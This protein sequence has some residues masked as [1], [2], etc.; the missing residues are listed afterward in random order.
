MMRHLSRFHFI[1]Q[2][3]EM[4]KCRA[5]A[6]NHEDLSH[7]CAD[8]GLGQ[9]SPSGMVGPQLNEVKSDATFVTIP[10]K[11]PNPEKTLAE[12]KE[13]APIGAKATLEG[14]AQGAAAQAAQPAREAA[15]LGAAHAAAA[16]AAQ[17]AGEATGPLSDV[18]RK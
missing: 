16:Q 9:E 2:N 3:E 15:A 12:L 1:E 11:I 17:P 10:K 4:L 8:Q 6:V 7:R 5:R 13:A 14:G 18:V